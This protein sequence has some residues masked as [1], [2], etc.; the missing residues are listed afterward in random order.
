[1]PER[2][3]KL[4]RVI[5]ELESFVPR[6]QQ[7]LPEPVFLLISRLTPLL[8]VDLLIQ[9]PAGRTLLTWRDDESYGPGWHVPGGIL[10]YQES[11]ADRIREVARLELGAQVE[12]EPEPLSIH[13]SLR[14]NARD[15]SH[16][17]SML[18]QCRLLTPPDASL[19]FDPKAPRPG[20]WQ[21]HVGCPDNLIREQLF[22]ERYL[23]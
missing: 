19:R 5:A 1:V 10:R 22:Y 13:G 18:Y 15:R 12:F 20:Q 17:I 11:A 4:S 16:T 21:W 9:D 14:P 3:S 6:P 7:G 23:R 8:G 2:S